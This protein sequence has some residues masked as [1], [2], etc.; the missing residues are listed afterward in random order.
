MRRNPEPPACSER[1]PSK[2]WK[3]DPQMPTA[4]GRTSTSPGPGSAGSGTS[5]TRI[6]P[7]ASVTAASIRRYAV[8]GAVPST[9]RTAATIL[10]SLGSTNCSSG[11]L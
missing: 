3:S 5:R 4:A 6:A 10:S 1:R 8:T 2:K 11:S 7:T 9:C